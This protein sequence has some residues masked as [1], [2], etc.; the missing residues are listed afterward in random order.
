MKINKRCAMV[1]TYKP[2]KRNY[3]QYK[4]VISSTLTVIY[5]I[6]RIAIVALITLTLIVG[7]IL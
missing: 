3:R 2:V 5:H 7:I 4:R 1:G 6:D